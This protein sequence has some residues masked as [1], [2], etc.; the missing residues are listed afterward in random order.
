MTMLPRTSDDSAI[1]AARMTC[2]YHSGKSSARFGVIAVFSFEVGLAMRKRQ[3][4]AWRNEMTSDLFWNRLATLGAVWFTI[5]TDESEIDLPP[6][7]R[8]GLCLA[9]CAESRG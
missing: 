3:N 1:S 8:P 9:I 6:R 5:S 4:Y 7:S 2:W